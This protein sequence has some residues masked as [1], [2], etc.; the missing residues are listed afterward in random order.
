MQHEATRGGLVGRLRRLASRRG[1]GGPDVTVVVGCAEPDED[2]LPGCLESLERQTH[3]YVDVRVVRC[4]AGGSGAARNAEAEAAEGKYLLFLDASERLVEG[5]LADLVG[6]LEASGSDLVVAGVRD[7]GGPV[8]EPADRTGAT[9]ADAPGAVVA[10]VL[11][12]TLFRRDFWTRAGLRFPDTPDAPSGPVL[13]RALTQATRFDLLAEAVCV[14]TDR[15]AELPFGHVPHLA[16]AV[17]PWLDAVAGTSAVLHDFGAA[18]AAWLHELLDVEA[19]RFVDATEQTDDGQWQRLCGV[20]GELVEEVSERPEAWAA[21]RW[22]SR[23]KAWLVAQRR[24]VVLEDF[25]E[26]RRR[27]EGAVRT[28][29]RDGRV[30]A[31]E[32]AEVPEHCRELTA[33]ETPLV[34]SLR[35]MRFVERTLE[36]DVF[37][38]ARLV[39]DDASRPDPEL[40][41][42]LVDEQGVRRV[43]LKVTATP[44]PAATRFAREPHQTHDLAGFRI[45]VTA[46]EVLESPS[47]SLQL[48]WAGY[49][50]ARTGTVTHRDHNG[51]VGERPRRLAGGMLWG[52]SPLGEGGVHLEVSR[53]VAVLDGA[54]VS[55]REV[56][57]RLTAPAGGPPSGLVAV[58]L[59]HRGH[60]PLAA[61]VRV[62]LDQGCGFAATLPDLAFGNRAGEAPEWRLAAVDESGA[63]H[64]SPSRRTPTSTGSVS[65]AACCPGV[66]RAGAPPRCTRPGTGRW[67]VTSGSPASTSCSAWTGSARSP[68]S[69]R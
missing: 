29:V 12:A 24:R 56:R 34:A 61:P 53:P 44:S 8:R 48:T 22:E 43:A 38:Y 46:D 20:L 4:A 50:L 51:T 37:A 32:P 36:L 62:P 26:A 33:A 27:A 63:E 65:P 52:P 66:A 39:G 11:G 9:L 5:A 30:F 23:V 13:V 40:A 59:S 15:A 18:R 64:R 42:E 1:A 69:G 54:A 28:E 25:V 14:A 45:S 49:G 2:L 60:P 3:E 47:W 16:D 57:G 58:E 35:Q 7:E 10:P 19:H 68:T 55:G 31:T 6:A 67:C 21:L 41:A 17:G